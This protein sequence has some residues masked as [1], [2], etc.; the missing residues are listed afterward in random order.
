MLNVAFC[1]L[2]YNRATFLRE[3]VAS[4]LAQSSQPRKIAIFDNGSEPD[5]K[6]AVEDYLQQGVQWV[7]SDANHGPGWNHKRA[8]QSVDSQYYVIFHD[9]DRI[10]PQF[11]ERQVGFM[12]ANTV[13]SAVSC[14]GY[15]MN[16]Q[17]VR[18]GETLA[19]ATKDGIYEIYDCSGQV[20]LKYARN[21]CIPLSPALYRTEMTI[22]VPFREEY[23]KV[24]DAVYFCDLT[25]VGPVAYLTA[26][27]YE[28]RQHGGQD[29]TSFPV[30]ISN[31]LEI[32]FESCKLND[33]SERPL[34]QRLLRHQHT[35]RNLKL[36]LFYAKRCEVSR[37]LSLVLDKRF[38]ILSAIG[39]VVHWSARLLGARGRSRINRT[40][41]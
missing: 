5:V 1:I 18:T 38:N 37:M 31:K 2:S 10:C 19:A 22:R 29:S 17:G 30:D 33:E 12:D 28:C 23:E 8:L 34:L 16:E 41:A 40:V 14:N 36:I 11:L 24:A 26:P 25:E 27:I 39:L 7:G 35:A 4:V 9:D 20:A 6:A 15:F 13:V 3:A 32:F 21:S